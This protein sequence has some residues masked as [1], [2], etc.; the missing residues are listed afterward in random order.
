MRK[1]DNDDRKMKGDSGDVAAVVT[2]DEEAV[3]HNLSKREEVGYWHLARKHC[4]G[5]S[6]GGAQQSH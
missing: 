3:S 6:P 1:V 5:V 2:S 4:P